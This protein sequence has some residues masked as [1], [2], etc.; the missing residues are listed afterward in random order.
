[1]AHAQVVATRLNALYVRRLRDL[2]HV[3]AQLA[4][5]DTESIANASGEQRAQPSSSSN[6]PAACGDVKNL[7]LAVRRASPVGDGLRA[8]RGWFQLR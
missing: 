2:Q 1:V 5:T 4:E 6:S 3:V 7:Q 8:Q